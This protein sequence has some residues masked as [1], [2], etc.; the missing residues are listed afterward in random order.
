MDT[1][2]LSKKCSQFSLTHVIKQPR[3]NGRKNREDRRQKKQRVRIADELTHI[4]LAS[5]FCLIH[6]DIAGDR[7]AAACHRLNRHGHRASIA[8]APAAEPAQYY[9][10]NVSDVLKR[11]S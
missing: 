9:P 3:A 8:A 1:E 10:M 11:Q 6:R 7:Q 2:S 5:F 4:L